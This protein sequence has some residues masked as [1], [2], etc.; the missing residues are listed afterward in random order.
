MKLFTA[1]SIM[2]A[3]SS[4]FA[5]G[6]LPPGHQDQMHCPE[7][8]CS[9]YIEQPLGFA[10]P[11]SA[12]YKCLDMET[13]ELI[14]AVWTGSLT[15]VVPPQG[16]VEDPEDCD[17]LYDDEDDDED[18]EDDEEPRNL[19]SPGGLCVDD[20]DCYPRIRG[21]APPNPTGP[22]PCSCFGASELLPWD[23]TE[24]HEHFRWIRCMP[25]AC[26]GYEAYCTRKPDEPGMGIS[27]AMGECALRPIESS[28][29]SPAPTEE[30]DE[31]SDD[32]DGNEDEEEPRN[33]DSPGGHCLS[34]S[35]CETRMRG[36]MPANSLVGPELCG[37]YAAS[38]LFPWDQT[39]GQEHFRRARCTEPNCDGYE[40]YCTLAPDDNGIGECALR[41][42]ES[43]SSTQEEGEDTS[44]K[45]VSPTPAPPAPRSAS[46]SEDLPSDASSSEDT[47][48]E[49]D[50]SNQSP[51]AA[52]M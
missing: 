48:S 42:I 51:P 1:T 29:T 19:D 13:D 34:D 32:E 44:N 15:D 22:E 50:E 12:F 6:A 11:R 28:S 49:D 31:K 10:G 30:K 43:T 25:G 18:D 5:R 14:D 7:G 37:C 8:S 23:Q 3:S 52:V 17:S 38:E 9:L 36:A 33:L 2:L 39:E 47:D 4:G 35:D 45:I 24:G 16:W 21:A 41:P 27:F 40:A 46:S 26:D 20:S